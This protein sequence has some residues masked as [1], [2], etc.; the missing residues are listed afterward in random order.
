MRLR[1][2]RCEA[3]DLIC[4]AEGEDQYGTIVHVNKVTKRRI[5]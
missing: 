1:G 2:P 3:L 5:P 4:V